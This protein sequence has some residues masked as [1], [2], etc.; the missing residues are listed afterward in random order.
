MSETHPCVNV[1]AKIKIQFINSTYKNSVLASVY[2]CVDARV[3]LFVCVRQI[4]TSMSFQS[5]ARYE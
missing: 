4:K 2:V 5:K 3:R 1:K